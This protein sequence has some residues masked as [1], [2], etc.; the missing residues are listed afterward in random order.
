MR[1]DRGARRQALRAAAVVLL[2]CLSAAG[3]V[4]AADARP[5]WVFLAKP[6]LQDASKNSLAL[7][8]R[9]VRRLEKVGHHAGA[10]LRDRAISESELAPLRERGVPIRLSSRWLRAVSVVLTDAEV[11]DLDADRRVV[12][13]RPVLRFVRDA[14]PPTEIVDAGTPRVAMRNLTADQDPASRDP[15]T[16]EGPDYGDCWEQLEMLGVPELHRL[17]YSGLGILIAL[18]DTGFYKTHQCLSRLSLIAERDFACGDRE[19]QYQ[20]GETCLPR[21]ADSHGTYTWSALGG[22]APGQQLG[23]AYRASFVL[24]RTEEIGHEVHLEE[25]SYIAAL[26][27]ADSLGVDIVSTSLGYRRFDD[28]SAYT[29]D[30][31]DGETI[32]IT[33]ATAIAAERGI[34]VVT[35][36][37][38]DGPDASTLVAPADGK[39]VVAVGA[40]DFGS[41]IASFSS[42]GPTGDGRIK[43]DVSANGVMTACAL[44]ETPGSYG[45]IPGTSLATPLIAGL[46]ALLLESHPAWTPDSV[47]SAL[48][49]S[50]DH[51]NAPS[52]SVG[53]GIADG[54]V[55]LGL[56]D[57][58]LKVDEVAWVG[59][60][61]TRGAPDWGDR[62]R[63][64][65]WFRNEGS[66]G[67][68][69][70]GAWVGVHDDRLHL[71]DSSSVALDPISPGARDSVGFP[72]Q[73]DGAHLVPFALVP[74]FVET[75]ATGAVTECKIHLAIPSPY[76]LSHFD[77]VADPTGTCD[78]SWDVRPIDTAPLGPL[79]YRLY[80]DDGS[81]ARVPLQEGNLDW[82]IKRW[83]DRPPSPGLYRY[84]LEIEIMGGLYGALEGPREVR[85]QPPVPAAI[86]R[87]YPNPVHTG[88]ISIPLAWTGDDLPHVMVFDVT[89]RE[90]R[91]LTGPRVDDGFPILEWDLKDQRGRPV[92]SGVYALRLPGAGSAR[93]LIAR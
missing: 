33:Q 54:P 92:P 24:A 91:L 5:Y 10:D 88:K 51:A 83:T 86:G 25:D 26:E 41:A 65:I 43:P 28:G 49:A 82:W 2:L 12:S 7:S 68:Q 75:D 27:W 58:R 80:R 59:A 11:R 87:P 34:L 56:S 30:Q 29:I 6:S 78:L 18:F 85:I 37:G 35:A 63:L 9:A 70:G 1:C 48:H 69:S 84:W 53:W 64:V 13:V 67:S 15:R 74:L 60:G 81:G 46:S 47:I 4:A 42:R 50:G 72:V 3:S 19:T 21:D 61:G 52:N 93:V 36:M 57:A 66:I 20:P 89:G 8:P 31:L 77:A 55:A 22:F 40:V 16:L 17:G 71:I 39:R 23:A 32:P 90:I 79:G 73:I 62:G 14:A 38:N 44:A 76:T 45:R